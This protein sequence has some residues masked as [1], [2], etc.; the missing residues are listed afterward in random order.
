MYIYVLKLKSDKIYIGRTQNLTFRLDDHTNGNGAVWTKKYPPIEVL[1]TIP[2]VDEYDEDKYVLKYMKTNGID[3]VRGGSFSTIVLDEKTKSVITR[4]LN[5][6]SDKCFRCGEKGHFVNQCQSSIV[7]EIRPLVIMNHDITVSGDNIITKLNDIHELTKSGKEIL[8]LVS[9]NSVD[10]PHISALW[11]ISKHLEITSK[12]F[13]KDISCKRYFSIN[14]VLPLLNKHKILVYI[15]ELS[16]YCL[17]DNNADFVVFDNIIREINATNIGINVHQI[18]SNDQPQK[19]VFFAN[20]DVEYIENLKFFCALHFKC[21]V[22]LFDN[23]KWFELTLDILRDNHDIVERDYNSFKDLLILYGD[24]SFNA[25]TFGIPS[26][27]NSVIV[28]YTICGLSTPKS[29]NSMIELSK[30]KIQHNFN[31]KSYHDN[32]AVTEPTT[33][34]SIVGKPKQTKKARDEHAREWVKNNLPKPGDRT[35]IQYGLYTASINGITPISTGE[36]ARM[37]EAHGYKKVRTDGFNKWI[38]N[39]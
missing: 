29:T 20:G 10:I 15:Q 1:E 36:F 6:S 5:G 4:M 34:S 3:N 9:D 26:S 30:Y 38:K 22:Q 31:L 17:F 14:N 11:S 18:I 39:I 28:N 2:N 23:G 19:I 7:K 37:I 35:K 24:G 21:E 16:L 12:L 25:R 33:C 27:N 13:S 8:Q 32:N